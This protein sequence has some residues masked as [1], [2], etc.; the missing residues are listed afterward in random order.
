MVGSDCRSP[1]RRPAAPP[2]G[3]PEPLPPNGVNTPWHPA[4]CLSSLVPGD[5]TS[6]IMKPKTVADLLKPDGRFV[7]KLAVLEREFSVLQ[8]RI[9]ALKTAK[10]KSKRAKK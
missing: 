5:Q 4:R 9:A 8:R 7:E 1:A 6:A 2:P 10:Q 3:L